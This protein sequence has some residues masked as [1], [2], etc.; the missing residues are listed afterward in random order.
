MNA[1]VFFEHG[2]PEVLRYTDVSEPQIGPDDVLVHV[3]ACA[4]NHLDLWIRRGIPGVLV[5]LPRIPGSDIAG[6][7]ARVGANVSNIQIGERVLLS[8]GIS[9]GHCAYCL[10]GNDNLCRQYTLFGYMVDG[11]CAEFV[12]SPA[13]NVIPIP[14][15]LTFEE[16]AAI[17]L[18]FLTAWHML[19][20]RA[21]LRPAEDVLVLGAGSGVGSAAIQIAK[22]TG[23]RV[24]ATAGS[25]EKLR[26][27][28]DL[29]ADDV[30]LHTSK[31]F[32][33]EVRGLTNRRGV[34]VVFEH[35]G[36][37]TWE[38]SIRSLAVG[39]RLVTCG[40]TT[41]YE[42]KIDLRYLF[43][44]HISILGSYMGSKS[45]LFAVLELVGRGLLDPVIDTVMPL[46]KA[47]EAH[48]RL[49]NREQFGKIVLQVP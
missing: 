35:V 9:C 49:E 21:D 32:S 12:K 44:R 3:R 31:D 34:D 5:P 42:G 39:G 40:A 22:V 20:T 46:S 29:G 41:G 36:E 37:A 26:K 28:K 24:I 14:G 47:A 13:V 15:D 11:G 17:P 16:A 48:A 4:L 43:S 23:A 30:I 18:V 1:V 25:E 2:G 7:V 10:S 45:E 38:Q 33:N 8:P 27:A 6:E 19:I